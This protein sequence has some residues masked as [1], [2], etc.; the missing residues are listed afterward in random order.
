L[1]QIRRIWFAGTSLRSLATWPNRPSL[2]LRTMYETSNRPVQ[3]WHMWILVTSLYLAHHYTGGIGR[4]VMNVA[5]VRVTFSSSL[6]IVRA[7]P[8]ISDADVESL[9]MMSCWT[10][11]TWSMKREASGRYVKL[12]VCDD[13]NAVHGSLLAVRQTPTAACRPRNKN[14]IDISLI[15]NDSRVLLRCAM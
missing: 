7:P 8:L 2:R 13:V 6:I 5:R 10:N 15:S 3:R 4:R 1:V 11:V 9:K 12:S 14:Y